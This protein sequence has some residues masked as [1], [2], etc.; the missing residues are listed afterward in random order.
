[1]TASV[2]VPQ[3]TRTVLAKT[4]HTHK[5]AAI[6]AWYVFYIHVTK[7][8]MTNVRAQI[9]TA[10]CYLQRSVPKYETRQARL[11]NRCCCRGK[12]VSVTCYIFVC[13]CVCVWVGARAR[14]LVRAPTCM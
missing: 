5:V 2:D 8:R 4:H 13:E 1:V 7:I 14:G 10:F 9:L 6:I 3:I 12:T 11:R